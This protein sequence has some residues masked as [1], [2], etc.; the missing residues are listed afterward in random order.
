MKRLMQILRQIDGKGYKAYKD[1][2]GIYRFPSFTLYVDSVQS[3][4]YAP[5]SL[6]RV[7]VPLERVSYSEEWYQ[8]R[9]RR[10]AFEDYLLRKWV[11]QIASSPYRNG[12]NGFAIDRPGQEILERTAVVIRED[13][14]EARLTVG[15]PAQGRTILGK[16][17]YEMLCDTLPSLVERVFFFSEKDERLVERRMQLVD[18]QQAIREELSRRNWLVFIADGSILPRVSGISDK[19]LREGKIIPFRSPESLRVSIAVP[20]GEPITGM[21]IP[22]GITLIVG[23]GYHGKSTLLKAIE[24]G[25]YDHIEEDGREYVIT[26]PQVVKVRAEDGRRVEKVNI[27]P[28]ITHLPFGQDTSRFTTDD[29]SGSTSQAASIMEM[30]EMGCS[31]LLLDEDTSATNFMIRDARMQLLVSKGKEPITPLIDKIQQLYQEKGVS[32]ILVLGG[33]GDYLDVADRVIMMDQYT[34]YDLSEQARQVAK[35]FRDERQFEGGDS[36]GEI[37][38]RIPITSGLKATKGKKEKVDVK[39]VHTIRFGLQQI[40]LTALEQLVDV[41]QTR[42][43]AWMIYQLGKMGD[44]QRTLPE[45][46]AQLYQ[47]IDRFSLDFLSPYQGKHPGYLALPRKFELAGAINRLRSLRVR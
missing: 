45:L 44:D 23:G 31:C 34:P 42:A 6:I 7:R 40:D 14:V 17:A 19:P 24:R 38:K 41:S 11:D 32:S 8:R 29:A 4:P 28:F 25:V 3:D 12:K 10:I 13:W 30:L 37:T 5:P 35:Q 2:Q 22:T 47:K 20:H 26:D 16:R 1:L 39:G 18:N 33:S 27:S 36:F 9:Y 46:I 15:L 21:A 43:I